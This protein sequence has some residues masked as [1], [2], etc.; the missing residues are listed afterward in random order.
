L[1]FKTNSKP[2]APIASIPESKTEA[3]T[4][5]T[6]KKSVPLLKDAGKPGN[7][8]GLLNTVFPPKDRIRTEEEEMASY[9]SLLDK[10]LGG[11]DASE[12]YV[13]DDDL[14][15][16]R[17]FNYKKPYTADPAGPPISDYQAPKP[18]APPIPEAGTAFYP[19]N[20]DDQ[21]PLPYTTDQQGNVNGFFNPFVP[22]GSNVLPYPFLPPPPPH[23]DSEIEF[24]NDIDDPFDDA[25]TA[26]PLSVPSSEI[27]ATRPPLPPPSQGNQPP[28]G[29]QQ[30][31][32]QPQQPATAAGNQTTVADLDDEEVPFTP[33]F[34][35]RPVEF[36]YPTHNTTEVPPG[37]SG[38]GVFVPPPEGFFAGR[39]RDAALRAPIPQ[40]LLEAPFFIPNYYAKSNRDHGDHDPAKTFNGGQQQPQSQPPVVL[41]YLP[42]SASEK[43]VPP[44]KD[45]ASAQRAEQGKRIHIQQALPSP[46]PVGK[47]HRF[48][49]PIKSVSLQSD[50]DVNY[51]YPRPPVNSDSE[52]IDILSI[53][54]PPSNIDERLSRPAVIGKPG[55][56]RVANYVSVYR[57]DGAGSYAY[58]LSNSR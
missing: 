28:Q 14:F 54:P 39:D 36:Y 8:Y 55:S 43:L 11:L 49:P 58:Q 23:W 53:L 40:Y 29:Q 10:D 20:S 51:N 56:D 44:H 17:G 45:T 9:N 42:P 38:P 46:P 19:S 2:T 47:I 34:A 13:A 12:V 6:T 3:T 52:L 4:T 33:L 37:P 41:H 24:D 25:L 32:P 16:V 31:T 7:P 18:V 35:D 22:G 26:P 21:R 15:V 27:N 57:F 48:R 50:I 5:T 30:P 1:R